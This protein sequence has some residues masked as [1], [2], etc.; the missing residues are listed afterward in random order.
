MHACEIWP[1]TIEWGHRFSI[2]YVGTTQNRETGETQQ[3]HRWNSWSWCP[4]ICWCDW[5]MCKDGWAHA[6]T[7]THT[8]TLTEW[9]GPGQW[10]LQPA[11]YCCTSLPAKADKFEGPRDRP[12]VR[13]H[14]ASPGGGFQKTFFSCISVKLLS[15]IALWMA[16]RI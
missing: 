3:I 12:C 1:L 9:D 16:I 4:E 10:L 7:H 8:H 11:S 2:F 14:S 6:H 5:L 13:T 15:S